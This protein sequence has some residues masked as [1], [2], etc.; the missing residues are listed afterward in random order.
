[1]HERLRG[2]TLPVGLEV[3]VGTGG[4]KFW[5]GTGSFL[6]THFGY[7]GP[8]ALDAS[9]H[10]AREAWTGPVTVMA[11]FLTGTTPEAFERELL[12]GIE[13][14]P[15]RTLPALLR[16]RL[17]ESLML[18]LLAKVGV[19]PERPLSRLSREER[20]AVVAAFTAHALPVL[21]V[22]GYRKAEVTA[23]GVPL[24]EVDP[25]TLESRCSPGLHLAGEILNVDG[26][27]GGY[28]FQ[29]AWSTGHVAGRS[30]ALGRTG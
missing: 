17:P 6:F 14:E 18:E 5:E 8:V 25:S 27:L 30:A 19:E 1:M 11:N 29:F 12:Q 21:E 2:V 28:N 9:R 22:M 3:L 15:R 4:R 13:H 26:R 24:A 16:G 23:G 10:V 20:R 7:S